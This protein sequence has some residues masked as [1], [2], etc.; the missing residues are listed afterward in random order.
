MCPS[1]FLNEVKE[2][3]EMLEAEE[4]FPDLIDEDD[5]DEDFDWG[6]FDNFNYDALNQVYDIIRHDH[7]AIDILQEAVRD[8]DFDQM[9]VIMM[10][11]CQV[12]EE[13]EEWRQGGLNDISVEEEVVPEE[14]SEFPAGFEDDLVP[15]T[16]P[17]SQLKLLPLVK[18]DSWK[19]ICRWLVYPDP[20]ASADLPSNQKPHFMVFCRPQRQDG[21]LIYTPIYRVADKTYYFSR[22]TEFT[23][24]IVN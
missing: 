14:V 18:W 1:L 19:L 21:E 5:D 2:I 13:Y 16:T 8:R 3:E 11:S 4:Y 12:I 23:C 24:I 17:E 9:I 22:Y 20:D 6:E 15:S 7:S 10:D